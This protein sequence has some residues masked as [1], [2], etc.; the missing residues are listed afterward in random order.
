MKRK[1]KL[2]IVPAVLFLL[3][4]GLWL[5]RAAL[6]QLPTRQLARLPKSVQHWVIPEPE[7][8]VLPAVEAPTGAGSL[9]TPADEATPTLVIAAD[10]GEKVS[11]EENP[12]PSPAASN[13]AS[14]S[15]APTIAP[16]APPTATPAPTPLPPYT[17]LETITHHRQDWNN[18][19]PATLAM[20]LS[21]FGMDITQYDTA[22]ILKP[23]EEDR[24]VSPS[25][26][27]AYVNENTD[28]AALP[29]VNGDLDQ[30]K[31]LLA[32]GFPVIIEV[33]LDPPGEVAWLEW[34]GHYLLAT[35]YDDENGQLWVFDSL[36]W[37]TDTLKTANS[38]FGRVY[39]YEELIQ[40]WPQF[41]EAY[42]V[43]YD[44]AR[45]AEL[46][47]VL[48]DEFDDQKMW[49]R[50]LADAKSELTADEQNAF[51]WFNL[52][53]AYTALGQ[54]EEAA[55]AYD[56]ARAIGL[57]WR[58]LWY[59]FGPYEAYFHVGRYVDVILLANTTLED[60]P[61]FEESFYYKGLAQNGLGD[62]DGAQ[63]SFQ[64]AVDFNPQF[65][66]AIE[67]LAQ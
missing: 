41:N 1:N 43:L 57:P 25:E 3:V 27:A 44:P 19:G 49:E 33:G 7:S 40:Y 65:L 26:M 6:R 9:L 58:M 38:P 45:E 62:T 39:D 63:E 53:S 18:C 56:Q 30:L 17:R 55:T 8:A 60:R 10:S 32:E 35:G 20:G 52:G 48:G 29:R 37:E 51:S 15:E 23:N 66:P 5:G 4:A 31:L 21:Y 14:S 36:I 61:Y 54:Y 50:A 59:Q 34:Y 11:A 12:T 42:I 16:T 28:Y 46:A 64:S 22:A 47:A 2:L 13:E 24:N 67:V